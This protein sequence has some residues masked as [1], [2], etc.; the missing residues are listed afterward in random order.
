MGDVVGAVT[1]DGDDMG[2]MTRG[3]EAGAAMDRASQAWVHAW[4]AGCTVR[5]GK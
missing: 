1:G 2:T 5:H 4:D 3:M